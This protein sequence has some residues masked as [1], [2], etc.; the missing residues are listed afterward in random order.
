MMTE[1]KKQI[2]QSEQKTLHKSQSQQVPIN[3]ILQKIEQ[4]DDWQ[5]EK[6]L[7]ILDNFDVNI[8][9]PAST[10]KNT[11]KID[12]KFLSPNLSE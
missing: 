6:L 2:D 1:E 9:L 5:K 7:E 8:S 4:L 11:E 10:K 12:F 3:A